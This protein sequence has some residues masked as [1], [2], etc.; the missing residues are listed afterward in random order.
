M[1]FQSEYI[2]RFSF[3]SP[4][5]QLEHPLYRYRKNN[6]FLI[7]EIKNDHVY[8]APIKKL[9]DPFDSS[10]AMSFDEALQQ[11]TSIEH[12]LLKCFF[13]HQEKWYSTVK[14][15]LQ[16]QLDQEIT[17]DAFSNKIATLIKDAGGF[18]P[19]SAIAKNIY[20]LSSSLTPKRNVCGRVA[21]FSET[22]DS[23]P[24]WSYYAENHTGVCLKYDFSL[25]DRN[26]I[27]HQ[28]ILE[29]LR[30]VWYSQN[31]PID[32]DGTFSPYVKSLQWAHE[33]EWRLFKKFGSEYISTPCLTE[34]Y[35]GV[36]YNYDSWDTIIDA[37][38]KLPREIK[39]FKLKPKP[40]TYGFQQ[41]RINY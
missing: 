38:N 30:K 24:M 11:R 34:I 18:F 32:L 25:L 29:S 21:C 4:Q 26:N 36:K 28:T 2:E 20:A 1:D 39:I 13:L 33:Q 27:S 14:S 23:I 3:L 41:I 17:L 35:L 12:Y 15:N 40:D 6:K 5:L 8:L 9:N 37:V 7:D 10:F 22:W 19:A 16:S 31:R